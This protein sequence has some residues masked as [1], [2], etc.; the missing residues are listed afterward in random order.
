MPQGKCSAVFE[1]QMEAGYRESEEQASV[2]KRLEMETARSKAR[3][4]AWKSMIEM[5]D[6]A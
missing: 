6:F 3:P 2:L 1:N 4:S 5:L